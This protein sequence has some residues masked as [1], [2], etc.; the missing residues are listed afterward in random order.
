MTLSVL[1]HITLSFINAMCCVFCWVTS[2]EFH[3]FGSAIYSF[4]G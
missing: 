4:T 1:L 3:A 2:H